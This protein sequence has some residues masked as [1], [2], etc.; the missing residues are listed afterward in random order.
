MRKP[1]SAV[2]LPNTSCDYARQPNPSLGFISFSVKFRL[3]FHRY[4]SR[5]V[6]LILKDIF[7]S[8]TITNV[9]N[10][11]PR[12]G[13]WRLAHAG[14]LV[15]FDIFFNFHFLWFT[16]RWRLPEPDARHL[17]RTQVRV[18]RGSCSP[19]VKLHC[20]SRTVEISYVFLML[21]VAYITR[22][23]FHSFRY[24]GSNIRFL[25]QHGNRPTRTTAVRLRYD[26]LDLLM[27]SLF[28]WTD[29]WI[30]LQLNWIKCV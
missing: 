5:D 27:F 7:L 25:P 30:N 13:W 18:L 6:L 19:Y 29:F 3:I 11:C 14:P 17:S 23:F 12:N 21:F 10:R 2:V 15:F 9:S 8:L 20:A 28:A 22:L 1:S 26:N 16:T 4:F 24:S